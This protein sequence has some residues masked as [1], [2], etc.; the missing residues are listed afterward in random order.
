MSAGCA[1]T[2]SDEDRLLVAV[3]TRTDNYV[4]ARTNLTTCGV[5]TY[6]TVVA[7]SAEIGNS[8]LKK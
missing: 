4:A 7:G 8:R 1:S 6:N 2:G 3:G 5:S